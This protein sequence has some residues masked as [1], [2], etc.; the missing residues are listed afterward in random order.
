M[1][2]LICY[3]LGFKKGEFPC[4]YLGIDLENGN[5]SHK[6]W[7]KVLYKLDSKIGIWKDKW[8][9]KAGKIT[10][11]KVVLAALPIY[12]LSCLPLPKSINHKLETKLRNFLWKDREED[13]KMALIKW[14]KISKPKELGGLGIKRLNRKNEAFGAKLVWRLY[15]EHNKKWAKILYNKYLDADNPESIFRMI[16][17]PKAGRVGI[18]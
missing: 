9:T 17:L 1:E 7:H 10:K 4:K 5:K 6:V 16:N 15:K 2:K 18:L 3:I 8:L 14:E 11:I 13:K 12:P